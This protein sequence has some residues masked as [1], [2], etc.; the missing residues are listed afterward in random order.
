MLGLHV[1]VC[2]QPPSRSSP[3]SALVRLAGPVSA[4]ALDPLRRVLDR[5]VE[6]AGPRVR[7]DL[8]ECSDVDADVLE[9]LT[10]LDARLRAL[11]GYLTCE[12][13]IH[14]QI[15]LTGAAL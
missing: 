10:A 13:G 15:R 9:L 3:S 12:G 6:M 11:G 4:A 7:V 8:S 1:V 5:A 2:L 14:P